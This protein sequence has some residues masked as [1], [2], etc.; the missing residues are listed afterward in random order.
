LYANQ[1]FMR[2][3]GCAVYNRVSQNQGVLM[4]DDDSVLTQWYAGEVGGAALFSALAKKAAPGTAGKW[5]AQERC[6]AFLG[7]SA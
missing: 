7:A 6:E 5:R 4:R 1:W 2:Y 3:R